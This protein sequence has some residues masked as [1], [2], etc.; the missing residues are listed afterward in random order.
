MKIPPPVLLRR[1]DSRM[2]RYDSRVFSSQRQK[3]HT[4]SRY[5]RGRPAWSSGCGKSRNK[6]T[7]IRPQG[8]CHIRYG[9]TSSGKSALALLSFRAKRGISLF[10]LD[11]A[12][13]EIPRLARNNEINYRSRSLFSPQGSREQERFPG[14]S[15]RFTG[16]RLNK[17]AGNLEARGGI[18]P[19]IKVLQTFALPLGDRA[20]DANL[21]YQMQSPDCSS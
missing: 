12:Q 7:V 11:L 2:A 15:A 3:T 5:N 21:F 6:I 4:Y 14:V 8:Q 13:G 17:L 19:P 10:L 16:A 9:F 20:S 18:E 1:W